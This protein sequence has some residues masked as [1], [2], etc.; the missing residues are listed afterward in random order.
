MP[1]AHR[2]HPEPDCLRVTRYEEMN[3]LVYIWL[4]K[5]VKKD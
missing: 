5:I 2:N 3:N 4:Y 1:R